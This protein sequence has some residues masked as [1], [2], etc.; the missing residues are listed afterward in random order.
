M[1]V[2]EW[3]VSVLWGII[4]RVW[5]ELDSFLGWLSVKFATQMFLKSQ[6]FLNFQNEHFSSFID[7][8]PHF[9][10]K[11]SLN[12]LSSPATKATR[13][14]SQFHPTITP[15]FQF[16]NHINNKGSEKKKI[17]KAYKNLFVLF[18]DYYFHNSTRC[19]NIHNLF[20]Y[21]SCA[22]TSSH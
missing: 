6:R 17:N 3:V 2:M 22:N 19:A 18:M 1:V 12:S 20:L 5:M 9:S 14:L 11:V 10:N 15:Q 7:T 8:K 13:S 4:L 16:T 21:F